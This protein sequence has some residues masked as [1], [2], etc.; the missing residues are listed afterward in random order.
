MTLAARVR[1][2]LGGFTLDAA[3]ES[4]GRLT[5]LFGSSGAGKTSLVNLI[6]G[7]SRPEE[8]RIEVDGRVLVDTEA[9]IFVPRH[10][11]RIGYVFQD[12]RLFPHLS[13]AQN[14][15]Y[16]RFFTPKSERY[17]DVAHVVELLGIGHLLDR[18]PG[19]LSGGE[20]QRVA[21]GRALIA[22]P[23]LILMDEPL[24]SLDEARKAEILP[25]IERLRDEGGIPIVYVSHS[26]AEVSRLATDVVML[27]AG[28][29]AASG[30]AADILARLDLLGEEGRDEAGALVDLELVSHDEMFALS[31]LRSRGGA[32]RLPRVDA[33]LG[34][35]LRA[36]VRARDVMIATA[37]PSQISALNVLEGTVGSVA[38]GGG[39][40]A[41]VRVD[42]GGDILFARVTRQSV[43]ALG[44]GPGRAVFV[45]VKAVSFDRSN[46]PAPTPK[47]RD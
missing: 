30:P 31:L 45:I 29:V 4:G 20:K 19:L 37:R 33:P 24:A 32:W 3:F 25:Y 5:A 27:T 36:R 11:R 13:V 21:I 38:A 23:R 47:W 18:K 16:G 43:Q 6:G 9:R 2:R 26:V 34:A 17:A 42:C 40:N 39:A 8:G 41:M 1:Q 10:R 35:R 12:A 28:R 46:S 22:S 15:R 7:L 14:L 44:L